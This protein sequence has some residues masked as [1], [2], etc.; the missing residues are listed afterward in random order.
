MRWIV[1]YQSGTGSWVL[2]EAFD[3]RRECLCALE[4]TSRQYGDGSAK[5]TSETVLLV[6]PSDPAGSPTGGT[7]RRPG[8]AAGFRLHC[9]P[10]TADPRAEPSREEH[11]DPRWSGMRWAGAWVMWM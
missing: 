1:W 6:F 8:A 3:T 4:R 5:R 2:E 11:E 9:R 7:P 10:S